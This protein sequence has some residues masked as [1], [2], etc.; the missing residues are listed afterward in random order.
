MSDFRIGDRVK[1]GSPHA[2]HFGHWGT[3]SGFG[4]SERGPHVW[5]DID[6]ATGSTPRE[7]YPTEL[8]LESEVTS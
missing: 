7:Y 5:V 3:V 8:A 1:V 6:L 4:S 2:P